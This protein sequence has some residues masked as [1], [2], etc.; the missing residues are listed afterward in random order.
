MVIFLKM[1]L[2]KIYLYTYILCVF[3]HHRKIDFAS[4]VK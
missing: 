4:S 3:V 1:K 2:G